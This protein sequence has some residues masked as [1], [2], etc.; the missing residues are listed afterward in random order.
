MNKL[1]Y[2]EEACKWIRPY[3]L[4]M[5]EWDKNL[6]A[7]AFNIP[8]KENTESTILVATDAYGMGIN[9]PDVRLVIQWDIPLSFD[10]MIQ[11]MSRAGRKGRASVFILFIPKWTKIKNPDEIE[12][13][14]NGTSSSISAN[15]QLSNSNCP[16][17]PSKVSPLS[18]VVNANEGD[19]S[20]SES[21]AGSKADFNFDGEV[22][23]FDRAMDADQDRSREK[24]KKKTSQTD[25]AKRAKLSNEI[26]DY[27]HVAHC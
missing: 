2:S 26:F 11:Q 17:L 14:I 7:Q 12:K 4:A 1:G 19:L 9:N 24:K 3:H 8:G 21:I 10:S 5:S 18:Q 16:K 23:L 6:I 13:C 25:A 15:A 27:I 20:N 22:N